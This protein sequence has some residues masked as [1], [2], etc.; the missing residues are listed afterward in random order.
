MDKL[1]TGIEP[2]EYGK[3][4]PSFYSNS[5]KIAPSS[6]DDM[7]TEQPPEEIQQPASDAPPVPDKESLG[8]P[9]RQPILV[10]DKYDG[11]DSDDE[12]DEE[13][14]AGIGGVGIG[15]SD[16]DEEED[17]PQVVGEV[18]I[19]MAEEED[20]FIEFAKEMLG[21]KE[22]Q[23]EN[24]MQ[25]RKDRGGAYMWLQGIFLVFTFSISLHTSVCY[26][27]QRHLK[28]KICRF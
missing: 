15:G 19:D 10:R 25:D 14:E 1:V 21:I 17:R 18:E 9:I 23:W 8:R 22:D 11:V 20:E 24:I 3:M 27:D 5:Q 12:T 2:S 28:V 16:D 6:A 4:P 7:M 13:D 26:K